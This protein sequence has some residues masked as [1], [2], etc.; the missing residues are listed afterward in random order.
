MVNVIAPVTVSVASDLTNCVLS[1]E[2]KVVAL[3]LVREAPLPLKVVA[4]Q[5][6]VTSTPEVVISNRFVGVITSVLPEVT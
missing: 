5:V 2:S 1:R 4:V 3:T 6:P